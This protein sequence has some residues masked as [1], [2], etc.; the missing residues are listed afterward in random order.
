MQI[1]NTMSNQFCVH[2]VDFVLKI[3]W[4]NDVRIKL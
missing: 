1:G 2:H 4:Y 3:E